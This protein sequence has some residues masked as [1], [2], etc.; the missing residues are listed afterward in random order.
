MLAAHPSV[1]GVLLMSVWLTVARNS[2]CPRPLATASAT[3]LLAARTCSR[4]PAATLVMSALTV[5]RYGA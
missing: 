4:M 2:V 5:M 3:G 1:Q